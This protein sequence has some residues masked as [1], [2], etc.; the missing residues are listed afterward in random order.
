MLHLRA[1]LIALSLLL[2]APLTQAAPRLEHAGIAH[3]QAGQKLML[4]ADG[5][6]Y[7]PGT[8]ITVVDK[9]DPDTQRTVKVVQMLGGNKSVMVEVLE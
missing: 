1:L 7:K 6:A 2:A 4:Q 9:H 5:K 8:V 3:V